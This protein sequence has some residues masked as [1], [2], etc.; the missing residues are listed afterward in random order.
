MT[1][2]RDLQDKKAFN[3]EQLI[4]QLTKLHDVS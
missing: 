1:V 2:W 4:R 3:L